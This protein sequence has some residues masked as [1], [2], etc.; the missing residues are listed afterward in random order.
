[1]TS[2]KT[3]Q[4]IEKTFK[5][6][7]EGIQTFEGIY[8]KIKTT[9]NLAQRDKLEDNLKREIKK[10]QRFRDQI[11]SWAS[12]NEV[13][14]KTPLLEQRKAIETCMEQFK[15]VE[16]EM[17]TKAYSKEGLSAASRLDP[18][19]KEKV[20]S[21]DFLSSCVDE[22]QQKI[23]AMEAEE[24]TL[25]MQMKKNKKDVSKTNRLADLT[26][27][28][29]RHKWHVTKLELLLRSVQ[30]GNIDTKQVMDVKESIKYY[31]EDGHNV[32]Y[33]GEDETLYDD[34]NLGDDAE[35]QFGMANE[36]DRVSSQDTQSV[37]EEEPEPKAKP[38]KP[39]ASGPRR[40]STQM[41]SP[42]PVL[43]TLHP[44]GPS[45]TATSMKPA[46]LPTRLPGETL[47]Y[48]SAAA[49]AAASD[50]NGVGIAPL[51]PPPGA[52][53]AFHPAVPSSKASSTA[54]PIVPT[55]QPVSKPAATV[56]AEEV[57][58]QGRT[59]SPALSPSVRAASTSSPVPPAAAVDKAEAEAVP[60][61]PKAEQ[62]P[63]T[64][65]EASAKEADE[66]IYHLPP[67]LQD[68]IHSFEVTKT[69]ASSTPSPSVQRLLAAS[70]TTCPEPSDAEK[71]RHYK[72][73]N[74]YNT[75]LYYPQ[76]PLSIFDDPR[77]YDTGRIDTDTLFYLFY[78]R[79]GSYQQYL[80]AKAL[81]NQSWRFHKQYQ[82]WFQ[83]HEEPKTITEEFEQGTYRFFDYESTWMNRR[84]ADFKFIYKYLED[85]L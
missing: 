57:G 65:G 75:P 70:L 43:A 15:A 42:L 50:K 5:K 45:V 59:K 51:P 19:E 2:R 61:S 17:K 78:Y 77:L 26:R 34:L 31:V 27:I 11:K 84:K 46:P 7:T 76:E 66:S 22:L 28:L 85:E 83:R 62:P 4:E 6:V 32:D 60:T 72:P 8:E 55:V 80:S 13:K 44:S 74:P 9:T 39:E 64:N 1:M 54:S 49:A 14:D 40:P 30:N 71:P 82:T 29:E 37:Q 63:T 23:E 12:G 38:P 52:S 41:K 67:G 25:H 36:N 10:L 48:A 79:Q 53:P 68:L 21:C 3:Q 16:K 18:K 24:E 33:S 56:I 20:E 47:K 73:Q 35:V 69:R 58:L 81:K